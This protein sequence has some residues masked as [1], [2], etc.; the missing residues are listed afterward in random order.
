MLHRSPTRAALAAL[1]LILA[2]GGAA[3]AAT[4]DSVA[5]CTGVGLSAPMIVNSLLPVVNNDS[6]GNEQAILLMFPYLL[7]VGNDLRLDYARSIAS[8]VAV[9]DHDT[10]FTLKLK[11]WR[12]SDG[13]PVT[14]DDVI[15]DFQLI[16]A[17]GARYL[18]AGIGG[19]PGIVKSITAPSPD[20]LRVETRHPVN[21]HWFELNGLTQLRP[22][23]RH[24]W[25][26]MKVD[27]LVKRQ[28][29]TAMVAVTDG[30]YRLAQYVAGRYMS[31]VANP[32][33][34]G[35]QP[36][37]KHFVLHMFTDSQSAFAALKTGELQ[38]GHVPPSLIPAKRM[39]AD[40]KGWFYPGGFN[41]SYI[42][43]NFDNPAVSWLR[44]LKV[45]QALQLAIDQPLLIQAAL[46]GLGTPNFGPVPAVPPTYL[47]PAQRAADAHPKAQYNPARARKLLAEAGWMPGPGGIR[48]KNG[49]RLTLTLLVTSGTPHRIAEAEIIKQTWRA[50]GVDLRIRLVPFNQE[51]AEVRPGGH[52]QAAMMAW[53]YAP[54]YYPT[55]DGLFD[56]GGGANYGNYSDPKMDALISASTS[57]PGLKAL[58]RYQDYVT[59]QLPVLFRPS[60]GYL[61]K[62]DPRLH[63]V[64]DY[65]SPLGYIWPQ[66]LYYAQ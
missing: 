37:I 31:F 22:L 45:R 14:A 43:L 4:P 27:E 52:W 6:V 25:H 30:P 48:R 13:S 42:A 63:G 60:P 8:G 47:S 57:D 54:D 35:P 62:Y 51:L 29:Q 55:G 20:T 61:V 7:W 26:D 36:H 1:S 34:S 24:A 39:V 59:E 18:N 38:L 56:T 10:V 28:N 58:Y 32:K 40:L 2:C 64:K 19:M 3:R 9:S 12:W 50:I 44:D 33:Y 23:P 46:H 15:Y 11:P 5:T 41:V 17:Y 66:N 16:R 49:Q 53:I 21:P 65:L